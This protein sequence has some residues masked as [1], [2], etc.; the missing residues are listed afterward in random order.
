[1]YSTS[2]Q[3]PIKDLAVK[4]NPSK[5]V[6]TAQKDQLKGL[7]PILN[8]KIKF[9]KNH[10]ILNDSLAESL[11]QNLYPRK[12]SDT[13]SKKKDPYIKKYK[14]PAAENSNIFKKPSTR[15]LEID[16]L[17][18]EKKQRLGLLEDT[19][20]KPQALGVKQSLSPLKIQH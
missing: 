10:E 4:L 2:D 13:T 16:T 19:P 5:K 11:R 12:K 3:K 7:D 8:E 15:F 20:D 14:V 6:N 9:E 1:M 17:S 18:A